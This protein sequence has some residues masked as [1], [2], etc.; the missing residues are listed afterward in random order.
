MSLSAHGG[1]TTP[2]GNVWLAGSCCLHAQASS[3]CRSMATEEETSLATRP[4]TERQTAWDTFLICILGSG[5]GEPSSGLCRALLRHAVPI[6]GVYKDPDTDGAML[7]Y[8]SYLNYIFIPIVGRLA[9][10][11]ITALRVLFF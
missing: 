7:P 2:G 9:I 11:V 1:D 8:D 4:A 5:P 6:S 3:P 10:I